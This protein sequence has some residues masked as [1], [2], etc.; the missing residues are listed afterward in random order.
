MI[1]FKQ[2]LKESGKEAKKLL[3]KVSTAPYRYVHRYDYETKRG[4]LR[5]RLNSRDR[6]WTDDEKQ[7]HLDYEATGDDHTDG[8]DY[9]QRHRKT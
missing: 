6:N 3:G 2:F 4:T 7:A 5:K 9:H 8:Y 1:T